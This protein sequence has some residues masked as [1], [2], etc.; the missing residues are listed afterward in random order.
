[1]IH[2]T[3]PPPVLTWPACLVWKV[4]VGDYR[5][6]LLHTNEFIFRRLDAATRKTGKILRCYR[7]L[8]FAGGTLVDFSLVRVAPRSFVAPPPCAPVSLVRR[9]TPCFDD[10]ACVEQRMTRRDAEQQRVV[11]DLYPQL[12]GGIFLVGMPGFIKSIWEGVKPLMPP[13]AVEKVALLD[14]KS[15][16]ADVQRILDATG[17]HAAHVSR[18]HVRSHVV[19]DTVSVAPPWTGMRLDQMPSFLRGTG[20]WPMVHA[21]ENNPLAIAA[22]SEAGIAC[23]DRGGTIQEALCAQFEAAEAAASGRGVASS[24]P[25]VASSSSSDGRCVAGSRTSMCAEP[26]VLQVRAPRAHITLDCP[27]L[28]GDGVIMSDV[29]R[30]SSAYGHA[31]FGGGRP[32]V[33]HRG[34]CPPGRWQLELLLTCVVEQPE[35]L[36]QNLRRTASELRHA[37]GAADLGPTL[38]DGAPLRVA[39]DDFVN[40][41]LLGASI[42]QAKRRFVDSAMSMNPP[43]VPPVAH[44]APAPVVVVAVAVPTGAWGGGASEARPVAVAV[45]VGVPSCVPYR[46]EW[47]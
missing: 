34:R 8:D 24:G 40:H 38:A 3:P 10:H 5:S 2:P 29:A 12:T 20:P 31:M 46:D 42:E 22:A 43:G 18:M 44:A 26:H 15:K 33:E 14:P 41:Q 37:H 6:F 21:S 32:W 19:L 17:T 9:L 30:G 4:P 47:L 27:V 7:I 45:P 23:I 11:Q 36:R 13:K 39:A 1:M 35:A 16:P 28:P 25:S